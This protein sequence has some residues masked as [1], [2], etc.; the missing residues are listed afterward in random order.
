MISK[1]ALVACLP[2]LIASAAEAVTLRWTTGTMTQAQETVVVVPAPEA[3]GIGRG[4]LNTE[5][6]EFTWRID[7]SGL[8]GPATMA[9]F[10]LGAPGVAG[11]AQVDIGAISGLASGALGAT[12]ISAANVSDLLAGLWYVNVHTAAN[13]AGEIRGQVS[14]APVPLPAALPLVLAGAG[15]LGALSLRRRRKA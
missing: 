15:A 9:H 3:M 1:I 2:V 8:T 6:G 11:P 13:T 5:T 4:R 12:T 10:H 7:Y 14:T